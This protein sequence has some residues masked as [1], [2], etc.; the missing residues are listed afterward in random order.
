MMAA[1][2]IEQALETYGAAWNAASHEECVRLLAQSWVA[3][4]EFLNVALEAPL[5]GFEPL[6]K[7]IGE[8]NTQF[9]GHRTVLAGKV[10]EHHSCALVCWRYVGPDGQL[11]LEGQNFVEFDD[12]GLIRRVIQFFPINLG[13]DA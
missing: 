1:S 8:T 11:T 2:D 12:S 10:V 13:G 9:A 3:E 7:Y 6:A 5:V 4:G